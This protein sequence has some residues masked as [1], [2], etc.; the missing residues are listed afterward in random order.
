MKIYS[1]KITAAYFYTGMYLEKNKSGKLDYD[2]LRFAHDLLYF[3]GDK[4]I[5]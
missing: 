5:G 1:V 4:L 3:E 2:F